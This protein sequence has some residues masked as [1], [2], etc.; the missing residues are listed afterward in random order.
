MPAPCTVADPVWL[1]AIRRLPLTRLWLRMVLVVWMPP[2][3]ATAAPAAVAVTSLPVMAVCNIVALPGKTT[4]IPPAVGFAVP[5]APAVA[6]TRLFLIVLLRSTRVPYS[7]IPPEKAVASPPTLVVLTWFWSIVVLLILADPPSTMKMPP[8]WASPQLAAIERRTALLLTTLLA[9]VSLPSESIPPPPAAHAFGPDEMA[10]LWFTMLCRS[11]RLPLCQLRMPPPT[12]LLASRPPTRLLVTLVFV[13]VSVPQLSTPPP[14]A[15]ANP[16]ESAR[17]GAAR[18]PVM[19]LFLMVTLAPFARSAFGGISIPPPSA[20]IPSWPA[21]AVD[22][23]LERATPPV[24]VTPSMETVGSVVAPKD[25]IVAPVTP[26]R[27]MLAPAPAPT[28]LTL[29]SMVNPPT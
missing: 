3:S 15:K 8:P 14:A 22:S 18:L 19:T 12:A 13:R 27:M 9:M 1:R 4:P 2:P 29:I 28:S 24:I 26:P 11:V 20:K 5:E 23:G 21:K 7:A 16:E 25:P 17:E 6:R 10:W